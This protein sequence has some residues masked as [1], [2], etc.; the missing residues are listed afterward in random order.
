MLQEH[1]RGTPLA[2]FE[3]KAARKHAAGLAAGGWLPSDR[4][5]VS[6]ELLGVV[7]RGATRES[8]TSTNSSAARK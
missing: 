7:L 4:G 5:A 1:A 3:A 2:M 8:K 6:V